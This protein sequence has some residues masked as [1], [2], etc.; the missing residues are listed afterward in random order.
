LQMFCGEREHERRGAWKTRKKKDGLSEK[1]G[2][3]KG[4][5]HL[6]GITLKAGRFTS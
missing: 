1:N 4:G 3:A 2:A 5:S 6:R